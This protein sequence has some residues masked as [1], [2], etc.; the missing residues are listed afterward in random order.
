M[1]CTC[2][3]KISMPKVLMWLLISIKI[4]WTEEWILSLWWWSSA[5]HCAIIGRRDSNDVRTS[6]VSL[7]KWTPPRL[8]CMQCAIMLHVWK[9]VSSP[10]YTTTFQA[11]NE[12]LQI[13]ILLISPFS[14]LIVVSF[15]L[16]SY[17]YNLFSY[18]AP[19]ISL[20]SLS[21]FYLLFYYQAFITNLACF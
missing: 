10:K 13:K 18:S 6:S 7:S 21:H 14:F 12:N 16:T 1:T 3:L 20:I 9:H 4:S 15:D 2:R 17:Y 8:V 11:L 5:S 19:S